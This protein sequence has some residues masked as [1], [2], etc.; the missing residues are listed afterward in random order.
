[1]RIGAALRRELPSLGELR[2]EPA[3]PGA[4]GE[5]LALRLPVPAAGSRPAAVALE[6]PAPPRPDARA[7]ASLAVVAGRLVEPG[8]L[9]SLGEAAHPVRVL[10]ETLQTMLALGRA[11]ERVRRSAVWG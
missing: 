8:A 6:S 2:A 9:T 7:L 3:L 1:M 11:V 5:E 10:A 4:E